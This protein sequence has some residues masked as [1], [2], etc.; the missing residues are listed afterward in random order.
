MPEPFNWLLAFSHC[1]F[2]ARIYILWQN[3]EIKK[4]IFNEIE[5]KRVIKQVIRFFLD[6]RCGMINRKT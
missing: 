2:D 4:G 5:M 1:I 3:Y 6:T